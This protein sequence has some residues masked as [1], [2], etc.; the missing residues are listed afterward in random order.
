MSQKS[1]IIEKLQE[2]K[3]EI[4]IAVIFAIIMFGKDLIFTGAEVK[5]TGQIENTVIHSDKVKVYLDSLDNAS[6]QKNLSIA[7]NTP[8]IWYDA[9]ASDFVKD[10]AEE[11]VNDIEEEMNRK[12][13]EVD[14]L[15]HS[16][17]NEIGEDLG[18]RNEDVVPLL[19]K[20]MREYVSNHL[21]MVTSPTF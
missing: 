16:F 19:K 2:K 15:Q 20:M 5:I 14:S 6:F 10:Y 11:K 13:T 3:I 1:K 21:P 7:L 9:L 4:I 12:I 18:I 8:M 17:I